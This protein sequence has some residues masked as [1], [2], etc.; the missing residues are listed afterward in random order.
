MMLLFRQK[1]DRYKE[2]K[3]DVSIGAL[4]FIGLIILQWMIAIL[5]RTK[6]W[7]LG[8]VLGGIGGIVLAVVLSWWLTIPA[9]ILFGL[10]LDYLVS[11]NY[12]ARGTTQ[13]WAGGNWG[14]GSRGG[15]GGFG[16]FGGGGFGGGSFGGGGASGRW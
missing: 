13:W 2:K 11:K 4:F 15:G 1:S 10:L 7:W 9:F 8:G 12:K 16:G 14:P 3:S 5:G 6:S